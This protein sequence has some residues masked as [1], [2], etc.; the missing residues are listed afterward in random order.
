MIQTVSAFGL[1]YNKIFL[2]TTQS[3]TL[4][5]SLHGALNSLYFF[6]GLP[7]NCNITQEAQK[8]CKLIQLH[9]HFYKQ[10]HSL[11]GVVYWEIVQ[12]NLKC[13]L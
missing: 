5:V 2:K 6:R 9:L 4:S 12:G 3:E 11:D 13:S 10:G 1:P 8:N 7:K